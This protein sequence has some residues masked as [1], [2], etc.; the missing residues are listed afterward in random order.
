VTAAG[1]LIQGSDDIS[2]I[3]AKLLAKPSLAELEDV[4]VDAVARHAAI[5]SEIRSGE[6]GVIEDLFG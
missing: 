1:E 3:H 5:D 6:F 4:R 2:A